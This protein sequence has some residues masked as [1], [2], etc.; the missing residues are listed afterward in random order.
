MNLIPQNMRPP[1]SGENKQT[2]NPI[3][4]KL[5]IPVTEDSLLVT[6]WMDPNLL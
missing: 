6:K 4:T 5:E 3:K 1:S 2:K